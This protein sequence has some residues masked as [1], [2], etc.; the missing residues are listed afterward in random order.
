[1]TTHEMEL[2][3]QGDSGAEEWHCRDC[4]RRMLLRWPPNYDKVVLEPGDEQVTHVGGKGGVR[5]QPGVAPAAEPEVAESDRSWL[6]DNG[7]DW[8]P[9][10]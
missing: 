3:G 2:A 7:I 4:G 8:G 10:A 1:M 5:M 9:A 6:R